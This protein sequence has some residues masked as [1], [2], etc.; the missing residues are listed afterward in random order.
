MA[1]I[2][3]AGWVG[4]SDRILELSSTRSPWH[5]R[6]WRAGTVE[7]FRE[8]VE[9]C[10]LEGATGNAIDDLREYALHVV[11]NDPAAKFILRDR[12][13]RTANKVSTSSTS[14]SIEVET[15]REKLVLLEEDYLRNWAHIVSQPGSSRSHDIEG[16]ARRITGHIVGN[17]FHS[18]SLYAWLLSL[19]RSDSETKFE[20]FLVAADERLKRAP[21]SF[22][23]CVPYVNRL[24]PALLRNASD[25][26]LSAKQTSEWKKTN[27][28]SAENFT[29]QGAFLLEIIA[30]DIN[31]AV[32]LAQD[33][34]RSIETKLRLSTGKRFEVCASMWCEQKP[35]GIF[36]TVHT[37]RRIH[38]YSIKRLHKLGETTM[39]PTLESVLALIE[40][41]QTAPPHLAI[42]SGWA[43]IES[44]L[45]SATDKT[46]AECA[47]RFGLVISHS[48]IRGEL[49]YLANCWAKASNDELAK[50]IATTPTNLDKARLMAEAIAKEKEFAGL[51]FNDLLAIER[52]RQAILSPGPEIEKTAKI[53]SREF[54]RMYRKRNL[55]VHGGYLHD[56]SLHTLSDRLAPLVG[57]GVDRFIEAFLSYQL[58][59]QQFMG[60]TQARTDFMTEN[61]ANIDRAL[62]IFTH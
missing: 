39:N 57:I 3:Q 25:V 46:N 6:L 58:S 4:I 19:K 30:F 12:L 49:T 32:A 35:S 36:P 51:P 61:N 53:L 16:A 55:I 5:R 8:F 50:R 15:L 21:A 17:G 29:F 42:I 11:H 20:E 24:D 52:M 59:P 9:E 10:A 28:D 62:S 40:P 13:G 14:N 2:E 41:L 47:D 54:R 1:I 7:V 27:A 33:R 23:F 44:L 60:R 48:L 37:D 56:S 31:S 38:T 45:S 22:N 34:I 43:A 18:S 26:W